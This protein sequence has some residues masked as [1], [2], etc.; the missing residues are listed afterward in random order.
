[1][2]PKFRDLTNENHFVFSHGFC[3]MGLAGISGSGT[4]TRQQ[5][6]GVGAGTV[7]GMWRPFSSCPLRASPCSLSVGAVFFPL[8]PNTPHKASQGS[9]PSVLVNT[10]VA[11]CLFMVCPEKSPSITLQC[12]GGS[13]HKSLPSSE[14]HPHTVRRTSG[15]ADIIEVI[16]GK[17]KFIKNVFC[18]IKIDVN[19][20]S[21]LKAILE[22][23]LI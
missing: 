2:I 12:G 14:C 10:M 19:I 5:A 21:D 7:E 20:Y 11:K 22:E 15:M 8:Q 23:K 3:R 4:L 16:L 18:F 1:M 13:N 6:D 9:S 17:C